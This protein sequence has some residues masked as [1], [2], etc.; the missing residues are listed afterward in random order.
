MIDGGYLCMGTNNSLSLQESWHLPLSSFS[1]AGQILESH[2]SETNPPRLPSFLAHT[3]FLPILPLHSPSTK[4]TTS[5]NGV[6]SSATSLPDPNHSKL[7]YSQAAWC[8]GTSLLVYR[9]AFAWSQLQKRECQ[10]QRAYQRRTTPL[11]TQEKRQR[12][13]HVPH[14]QQFTRAQFPG[15]RFAG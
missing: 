6:S 10:W 3:L 2:A 5:R 11:E 4:G 14:W 7:Q 15:G 13:K 1:F 9:M 8:L 12:Q